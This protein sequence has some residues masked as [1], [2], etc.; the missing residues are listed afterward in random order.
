MS[1]EGMTEKQFRKIIPIREIQAYEGN[2]WATTL[3]MMLRCHGFDFSQTYVTS[4]FHEWR[5][6]GVTSKQM[7]QLAGFFNKNWLSRKGWVMKTVS[8]WKQIAKYLDQFGPV[9]VFIGG[10][11]VLLLG[12]DTEDGTVLYFDPWDGSVREVSE[13]RFSQLLPKETVYMYKE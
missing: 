13:R 9:Q 4:L 6:E 2:C 7:S 10:H 8:G 5:F 12:H 3:S 1:Y 11:F